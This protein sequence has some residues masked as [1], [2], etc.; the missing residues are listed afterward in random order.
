MM[1]IPLA[2]SSYV[3]K[4]CRTS[5]KKQSDSQGSALVSGNLCLAAEEPGRDLLHDVTG[6]IL[7]GGHSRRMGRNKALL[8]LGRETV[9]EAVYRV[10][11]G[12]FREVIL[13]CNDPGS[14][15][16]LDCR[17]V[18]DLFPG[19]GAIGGLHAGLL[20]SKTM[21]ICL[22]SCDAPFLSRELLS[23]LC[24][25]R[26]AYQAVVP[27]TTRGCKP[28]HAVYSRSCLPVLHEYLAGQGKSLTGLLDQLDCRY[29]GRNE[30]A[31]I[32][33]AEQSFCSLS[34]P[35]DYAALKIERGAEEC[36]AT[37]GG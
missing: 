2:Y 35:R 34:C 33:D 25:L 31:G 15:P 29:V 5:R 24:R 10:M 26:G 11:S 8:T 13:V 21:S 22:V 7:A 19:C 6:V 18:R 3:K 14:Y 16:C 32:A 23:L 17:K 28:L 27:V 12:L 36:P 1:V 30:Y 37:Q 20:A 4:R 9:V